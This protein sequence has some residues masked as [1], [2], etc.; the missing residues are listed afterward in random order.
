MHRIGELLAVIGDADTAADEVDSF[1]AGFERQV[2]EEAG[3]EAG[4]ES[5][6]VSVGGREIAF[7]EVG[8]GDATP[9]LFIH[10]FTGDRSNWL[11]NRD[12]LSEGR[13][14]VALDLPGHGESEK[15]VGG[16][17]VDGLAEL[18][19]GF[20][21]E[22]GLERALLVG[23]SLGGGIAIRLAKQ[24]PQRVAGLALISSF[25]LGGALSRKF[26]DD[27]LA[28]D[29]RKGMKEALKH[30]FADDG[31]LTRDMV[32]DMLAYK[33][34]DGVQE[35]LDRLALN[36]LSEEAN[37]ALRRDFEAL[38]MSVLVLHGAKDQVIAPPELDD[39]QLVANVQLV[40]DAGHM[41]H[42]E[43]SGEVNEA[44]RRFA[45]KL[46]A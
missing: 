38:E 25:G 39:V 3:S 17:T 19:A 5:K 40:A 9:V 32:N 15:D 24:H 30:L 45:E 35:A 33:R 7:D 42:M 18:I 14:T 1:V 41:P 10:G 37:G 2:P 6:R 11:F 27:L 26:V 46:S 29:R 43:K 21:K 12:V 16:G 31:A 13:R 22:V 44:L 8:S 4:A 23:H 36:A 28:A 20:M 34:L